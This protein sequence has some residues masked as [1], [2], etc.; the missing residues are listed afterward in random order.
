AR[1]EPHRRRGREPLGRGGRLLLRRDAPP[2]GRELPGA[3]A[4]DGGP[5]AA[6]RRLDAGAGHGGAL[7][8]VLAPRA[9]VPRE[10]PGA[11][12]P[13]PAHGGARPARAAAARPRRSG[14]A[15]AGPLADARRVGVPVAV[16]RP[17][18]VARAREAP[19]R[20]AHRRPVLPRRLRAGRE[21]D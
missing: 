21:P 12:G 17:L 7:P 15:R 1:D 5:D 14:E 2:D 9:L 8:G 4:L 16:R 20:A 3:R 11:V 6:L 18:P 10:P 19:L 13:L